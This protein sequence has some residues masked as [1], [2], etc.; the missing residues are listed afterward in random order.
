LDRKTSG[1]VAE[2]EARWDSDRSNDEKCGEKERY[3]QQVLSERGGRERGRM[4]EARTE[5]DVMWMYEK[6]K[7]AR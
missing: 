3:A 2:G 6:L 7:E 5:Y 4:S 1:R